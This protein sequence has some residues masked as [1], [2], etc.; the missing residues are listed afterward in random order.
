VFDCP[1][2][3]TND[4]GCPDD[5]NYC[6]PEPLVTCCPE[7]VVDETTPV[8]RVFVIEMAKKV[9]VEILHSFSGRQF[10]LCHRIVRPCRDKCAEPAGVAWEYGQLR[11]TLIGGK[12]F[13][14]TCS[15]CQ[16][17]C[18]CTEVCEVT[19]PGPVNR[20]IEI[21]ID[22]LVLSPADYRVDNRRKLVAQGSFCWPTCQ[23]MTAPAGRPGPEHGPL[24][25]GDA[26]LS[27][28]G[29]VFPGRWR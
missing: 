5:H 21:K 9:A 10:G 27:A 7:L 1:S 11:P 23:D 8:E 26:R 16:S 15:S 3:W 19:L 2:E 29:R 4:C 24:V 22:G 28:R 25:G 6:W 18:S 12:W 20:I 13:N 17:H 14:D